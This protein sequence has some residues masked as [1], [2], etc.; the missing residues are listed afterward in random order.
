[1]G[2]VLCIRVFFVNQKEIVEEKFLKGLSLR[3]SSENLSNVVVSEGVFSI[4]CKNRMRIGVYG[5]K[6]LGIFVEGCV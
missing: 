1:M 4:G 2:V 3:V 5:R 6:S